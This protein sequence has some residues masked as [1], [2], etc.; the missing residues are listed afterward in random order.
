VS[1]LSSCLSLRFQCVSSGGRLSDLLPVN[2]GVAQGSVFGPLL[3]SLF[4]DD[5]CEAVLTSSY[6]LYADD[7][8]EYAGGRPCDISDCIHRLN[9]AL[10]EIFHWSG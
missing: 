1:F 3:F 10:E 5:L 8:Q 6:H 9:V 2:F 4:I 7:F